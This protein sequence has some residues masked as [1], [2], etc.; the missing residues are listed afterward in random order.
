MCTGFNDTE[1]FK[2]EKEVRDEG[3]YANTLEKVFTRLP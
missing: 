3:Y 2:G 1:I